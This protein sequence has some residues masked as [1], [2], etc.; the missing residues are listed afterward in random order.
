VIEEK[1]IS[2][3]TVNP[4]QYVTLLRAAEKPPVAESH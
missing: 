2:F 3:V 4:V 1:M